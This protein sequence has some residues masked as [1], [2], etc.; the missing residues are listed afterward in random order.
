MKKKFKHK[1]ITIRA[2]SFA[3]SKNSGYEH[4]IMLNEDQLIIDMN[5]KPV[6]APV[7]NYFLHPYTL[8]VEY[9]PDRQ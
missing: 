1:N 9:K 4:G 7:W 5:L 6:K 2:C 3:R 8:S